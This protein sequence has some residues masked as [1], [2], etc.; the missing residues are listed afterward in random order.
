MQ[1]H[2][3]RHRKL[4]RAAP[5][6]LLTGAALLAFG[7][8]VTFDFAYDDFW[9]VVHNDALGRPLRWVLSKL[10]AGQGPTAGIPDATRPALVGCF[11][12]ERRLFGSRPAGYHAD[13]LLLY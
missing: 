12:L 9:T 6:L 11:W 8:V 7:K 2:P 5:V 3:L 13:S 10:V 1:S 4:R